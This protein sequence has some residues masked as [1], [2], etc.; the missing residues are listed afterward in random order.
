MSK[1]K[2]NKTKKEN[3]KMN[4]IKIIIITILLLLLLTLSTEYYGHIDIGDYSDVAKFFSGDLQAKLRTSHS[5]LYGLMHAPFVKLTSSFLF[6]KLSSVLWLSL[7]II[8]VY[9]IS[10]K[11]KKTLLL[12]T[13]API[14]WYMAPWINP[15]QLSSLLFLW[16]YYFIK[17]FEEDENW[18]YLAYSGLL[19]GLSSI[20]WES[21]LYFAVI[22]VLIFLYNKKTHNFLLFFIAIFIGM[23]PKLIT[24]Y[25]LFGSPFYSILKHIFA[26]VA[27]VF[28]SGIYGQ[29]VYY[30]SF[31]YSFFTIILILPFFSY[32]LF[33]KNFFSENKK[34][35][36]FLVFIFILIL[37][38][39][40]IRALLMIVPII[41]LIL[42]EILTEKQYRIQIVVFLILTLLVINPYIIQAKYE[43]NGKEFESFLVNL[44]NLELSSTSYNSILQ[45]DL[46]AIT[47]EFPNQTF[48]VG[49]SPDD[50]QTLAHV[51]WGED[52]EEFVSIQDYQLFLKNK[53]TIAEKTICSSSKTWNRRDICITISLEKT[54][55]DQT[56]YEDIEYAI[57]LDENLD[58]DNFKLAKTYK[59]L[60]VFEKK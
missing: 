56:D 33:T 52:I 54:F 55:N 18:R 23:L 15:I 43:T 48:I 12:I 19:A 9:Y 42:G 11:N 36:I 32:L 53:T 7:I 20:F 21:A 39:A 57:S 44:P 37:I 2:N 34:T 26:E 13:T 28:F 24:D 38:N 58:L 14:I 17:K 10:K 22:L 31:I 51:Y 16:A 60:S 25:I 41:I 45:E 50:Y 59:I 46:N 30:A 40:Q 6:M 3:K 4:P 29:T 27:F 1:K 49:N 35:A 5:V 8:S 47:T